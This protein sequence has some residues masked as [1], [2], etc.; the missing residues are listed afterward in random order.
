MKYSI[1]E[2]GC[3][4]EKNIWFEEYAIS[5]IHKIQMTICLKLYSVEFTF[6]VIQNLTF[7]ITF[8]D[9]MNSRKDYIFNSSFDIHLKVIFLE[10]LS[11]YLL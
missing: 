10:F 4:K 1:C 6:L 2:Y 9:W 3:K 7:G 5:L 8:S 11:S